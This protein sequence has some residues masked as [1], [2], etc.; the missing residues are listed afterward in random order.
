MSEYIYIKATAQSEG[1][2]H[3]SAE[4]WAVSKA[5]IKFIRVVTASTDWDL[6]LLQNDNGYAADDANIPKLQIMEAG[7]GNAVIMLNLAYEDED[8]SGE[9]HLYY[10]DNSGANTADI[11]VVGASM[12]VADAILTDTDEL[13]TN[14]GD[15]ATAVGFATPGNV[16][17]A[18]TAILAE[19]DANEAKIDTMQIDVTSILTDTNEIQGLISDSKMAA[20]VK[21][22][23][24][25]DLSA[26][27]K[28]SVNTEVDNALDTAIPG[29]PT[30]D[31]INERVAAI[32]DKLPSKDYL[33]G[34]D[35]SDGDVEMDEATG[36]FPG[37]VASVAGAVGSVAGAVGS[38]TGNVGGS[39]GS[40]AA[41]AKAD[42]NDQV[43]DV[44]NVDTFTEPGQGAPTATPTLRQMMHYIYKR[45][46]NKETQTS[47]DYKLYAND[48]VTV[49]QK[50]TVSDDGATFTKGE[51]GTG[52]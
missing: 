12:E 31:S 41:Q 1:D 36:N 47:S 35:N 8:A 14:Q 49:D 27:M 48:G 40:L 22:I 25:I 30:A 11:Y 17:N 45:W 26:T 50:A 3:L 38:V 37:S 51:I 28:A 9:V 7:N 34:T 46:R 42:V 29:A 18:Q 2:L 39:V 23:D 10:V 21:G 16:S 6:Y 32:D 5:L 52:A 13:Q 20:Q 19:I 43:L 4:S 33:A 15:W 44:I 24:N